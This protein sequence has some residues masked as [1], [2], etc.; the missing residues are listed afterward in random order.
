MQLI[1]IWAIHLVLHTGINQYSEVMFFDL[2]IAHVKQKGIFWN[3]YKPYVHKRYR[4]K[5]QFTVK[6]VLIDLA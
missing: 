2:S 3:K 6:L 5:N 4:N 1:F